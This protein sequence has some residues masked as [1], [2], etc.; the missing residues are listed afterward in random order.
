MAVWAALLAGCAGQSLPHPDRLIE[1]RLEP[2]TLADEASKRYSLEFPSELD[3]V[4]M[5]VHYQAEH[6]ARLCVDAP[7]A[8]IGRTGCHSVKGNGEWGTAYDFHRARG[9]MDVEVHASHPVSYSIAF[10]FVADGEHAPDS[11]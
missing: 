9:Q 11:I 1:D 7:A 6:G 10:Q 2:G 4:R 8:S 3:F 5:K